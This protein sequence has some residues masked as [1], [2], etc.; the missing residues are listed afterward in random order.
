M[1]ELTGGESVALADGANDTSDRLTFLHDMWYETPDMR[2]RI[3]FLL[4]AH[5][6]KFSVSG[7][8]D[9]LCGSASW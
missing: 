8:K 7:M 3:F 1:G 2:E 5:I 6:E 9:I 4:S